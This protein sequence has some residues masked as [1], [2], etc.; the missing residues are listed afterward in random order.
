MDVSVA[1]CTYNGAKYV[2]AQLQ[3]ILG[4]SRPPDEI[5]V[6]DDGSTDGTL[7]IVDDYVEEY[8]DTIRVHQNESTLG[9]T[10]NFEK[11]IRL[12]N[13]DVIALSD[14]D[15]I[16][17]ERKLEKQ[18]RVHLET[19]S[20]LTFHNSL[21]VDE[22]L[23]EQTTLWDTNDYPGG[24]A[25][26]PQRFFRELLLRN[27]VQGASMTISSDLADSAMPIPESWQHDYYL[28]LIGSITG[29]C[30]EFDDPLLHYRQHAAQDLGVSERG[31]LSKIKKS[32]NTG[33]EELSEKANRW[34]TLREVVT[35]LDPESLVFDKSAVVDSLTEREEYVRYRVTAHDTSAEFTSRMKAV[36]MNLAQLRYYRF[37]AGGVAWSAGSAG[38]SVVEGTGN[39]VRDMVATVQT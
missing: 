30:R 9:V 2:D 29:Y 20:H 22:G 26:N 25:D 38:K 12:A 11:A 8:P 16:W 4:Q 17:D 3:S 18:S 23:A 19:D 31:T 10:K 6:C 33:Y 24:S 37:G 34:R 35:D 39:L 7:E 32:V 36:G 5:V 14:Q 27:V 13:G 1:L 15:D 21:V 28:A